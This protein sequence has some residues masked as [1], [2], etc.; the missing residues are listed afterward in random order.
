VNYLFNSDLP[1][2]SLIY[3]FRAFGTLFLLILTAMAVHA[4][5]EISTS[6][7]DKTVIVNDAP[8]QQI[9][10]FGKSVEVRGSAKGVLAVGGDV[11]IHGNVDGDVG[12]IGGNVIQYS[13][14]RVGGDVMVIGGTYRPETDTPIREPGAQ[15]LVVGVFEDQIRDLA[16]RP[17]QLLVPSLTWSFLAQRVLLSLF[18]F[19]IS[20]VF[21]TVAPG[22][23]GRAVARVSLTALK[24]TALGSVAFV[25][26]MITIVGSVS[27]LPDY[28]SVTFWLMGIVLL[29][30]GYVFGR[31]TLQVS[32]GKLVQRKLFSEVNRS[33]TIATLIGV[34]FW[35]TLLSLP[36]VWV[37]ALFTVFAI[38]I[39]LILT[40]RAP[41]AWQKA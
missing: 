4:S 19:V 7:D 29:L 32:L 37:I 28:L 20:L 40:A 33:E 36:Y 3:N 2:G 15:T 38:G 14:G 6:D 31:V 22:A 27:V 18:W 1:P 9:Y 30:F 11:T 34:L 12:T 39:G 8:E 5:P 13:G 23:V 10:V 17:S 21:T 16:Q 41:A 26:T 24:V 35:T 25:L